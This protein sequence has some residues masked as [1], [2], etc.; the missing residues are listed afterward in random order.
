MDRQ[1]SELMNSYGIKFTVTI[2]KKMKNRKYHTVFLI[3]KV[4][5]IYLTL[6][7]FF[8]VLKETKA[9]QYKANKT[10]A[11]IQKKSKKKKKN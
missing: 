6:V 9:K 8:R 4:Q 10:C 1:M 3:G 5:K 7:S 11:E 2:G